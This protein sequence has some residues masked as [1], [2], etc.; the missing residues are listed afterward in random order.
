MFRKL[1]IALG[2]ILAFAACTPEQVA[3]IEKYHGVDFSPEDEVKLIALPD[4]DVRS[5]RVTF[6][7]DGTVT[8]VACE[9]PAA[10]EEHRILDLTAAYQTF[11]SVACHRG[12]RPEL[13]DIAQLS[14]EGEQVRDF[15][16]FDV[17]AKESMGCFSVRRAPVMTGGWGDS[18]VDSLVRN[19]GTEDAGYG[20]V[21]RSGWGP[22]GVVCRTTGLCS[23]EQIVESPWNSMVATVV[24]FENNGKQPWCYNERAR[25]FHHECRST[26]AR[27]WP[28]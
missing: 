16:V 19:R 13:W 4:Q 11:R 7:A 5:G 12:W 17:I 21:T 15:L 27:I 24:F 22:R 14:P 6:H 28:W 8:E 3:Q 18:C 10:P 26:P 25:R 9:E 1:T 2:A 20:Q 23:A